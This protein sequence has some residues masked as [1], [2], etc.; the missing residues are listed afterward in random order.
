M[1]IPSGI[2]HTF[3]NSSPEECIWLSTWSPKG[4]GG[5]FREFGVFQSE[6][7]SLEKSSS[8]EVLQRIQEGAAKYGMMISEVKV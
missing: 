2:V 8:M 4:F 3:R 6:A 7:G 1:E 5:F